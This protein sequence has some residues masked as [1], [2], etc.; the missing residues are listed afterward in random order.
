MLVRSHFSAL[1]E[2]INLRCTAGDGAMADS[3]GLKAGLIVAYYYLSN[4]MA[5]VVKVT[6]LENNQDEKASKTDKFTDLSVNH[7]FIFGDALHALTGNKTQQTKLCRLENLPKEEDCQQLRDYMIQRLNGLTG[8]EY[9]LWTSTEYCELRDL[10]LS[11]LL[12]LLNARRGGEPALIKL[13]EWQEAVD[14]HWLD[15]ASVNH[16]DDIKQFKLTYRTGKGN[17]HL[18]PVLFPSDVVTATQK[19]CNSTVQNSYGMNAYVF[20]NTKHSL[21]HVSEWHSVHRVSM[22][23]PK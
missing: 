15:V 6:L 20:P 3:G 11:R 12:T 19:L 10:V 22:D 17:N 18:V 13:T 4:K 1:A 9:R 7:N 21:D 2:A 16:C 8:D 14:D 23:V 5:K